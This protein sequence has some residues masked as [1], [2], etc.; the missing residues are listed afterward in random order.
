MEPILSVQGITMKFGGLVAL[1]DVT[2]DVYKGDLLAVIGPNGS[3]KTTLFNVITGIYS[4]AGGRIDFSGADITSKRP[5]ETAAMGISR[6][7]QNI[8]L[9]DSMT[10]LENVIVGQHSTTKAGLWD[11]IVRSARFK[12]EGDVTRRK[13][14]ELVE[15]VGLGDDMNELA[16]NLPYGKQKRLEIARGLASDPQLL[17]LDEPMAGLNPTEKALA[18]ELVLAVK[19]RGVTTI[20]IE[21]DM[22]VVMGISERIE[23]LNHGELIARGTPD[24][25]RTNPRVIE[26]YL[27]RQRAV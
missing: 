9:F 11:A 21:H 12:E 22:K 14:E 27:G 26:A 18:C 16:K 6:T 20:L 17:L 13:A 19:Q 23:V 7:F 4:P 15:F 1:K 5:Y 2:F 10:V 8:N 24:E 25:V 3:G